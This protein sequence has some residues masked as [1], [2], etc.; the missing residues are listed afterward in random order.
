[1]NEKKCTK[2]GRVK[3]AADFR[4]KSAT[5]HESRCRDCQRRPQRPLGNCPGQ[6]T[7]NRY[8]VE[9]GTAYIELTDKRGRMVAEA[10]I[11]ATD[12]NK[13]I[14]AGRWH[15]KRAK[16]TVYASMGN[17]ISGRCSNTLLHRFL[18]DPP[19][20]LVV[21]HIN[22]N[23]LDNRRENLRVVTVAENN[24]NRHGSS[25][26]S[27]TPG[28]HHSGGKWRVAVKG[29]PQRTFPTVEEARDYLAAI[30]AQADA[31]ESAALSTPAPRTTPQSAGK[32]AQGAP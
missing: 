28:I 4:R 31:A 13:A 29:H 23:G 24:T 10:L 14:N 21:D 32:E 5:R 3:P 25:A 18:L 11:D 1:M 9:D 15:K 2:C 17:R 30:K 8:R 7:P 6:R 20:D 26:R 12:I 27:G 19:A 22:G 16:H